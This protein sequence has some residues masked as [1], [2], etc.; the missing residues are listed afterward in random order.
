M[1][2]DQACCSSIAAL[3]LAYHAIQNGE[4]EAAIVGGASLILHP[5]SS[6]HTG[7]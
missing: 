1:S 4:C 7:R 6:V 2:V 5:Q 3:E